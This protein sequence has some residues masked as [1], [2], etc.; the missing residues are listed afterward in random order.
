MACP[1]VM[2]VQVRTMSAGGVGRR[3]GQSRASAQRYI[4]PELPRCSDKN[5]QLIFSMWMRPSCS[6]RYH[7]LV[8]VMALQSALR[9]R[10]LFA[11]HRTMGRVCLNDCSCA[12][13]VVPRELTNQDFRAAIQRNVASSLS[14]LSNSACSKRNPASLTSRFVSSGSRWLKNIGVPS[15]CPNQSPCDDPKLATKRP[16]G[17]S[18]VAMRRISASC[19]FRGTWVIE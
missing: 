4:P 17:R 18:Q 14:C 8:A 7:R 15:H 10:R 16:F 5:G 2:S 19:S 12:Q 11:A 13:A 3:Q 1:V 9:Q 6:G